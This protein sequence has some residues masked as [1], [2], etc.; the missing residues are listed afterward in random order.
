MPALPN[1]L[2]PATLPSSDDIM[3]YPLFP[4]AAAFCSQLTALETFPYSRTALPTPLRSL[5]LASSSHVVQMAMD[6]YTLSSRLRRLV[7]PPSSN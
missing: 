1:G 4:L 7:S 6:L 3:R 5:L 2:F